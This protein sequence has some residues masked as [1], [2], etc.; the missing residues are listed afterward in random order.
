[1]GRAETEGMAMGVEIMEDTA[2]VGGEAMIEMT[3]VAETERE[4]LGGRAGKRIQV[5][6]LLRRE[7][8]GEAEKRRATKTVQTRGFISPGCLQ[9]SRKM[10]CSSTLVCSARWLG[11]SR[12]EGTQTS[13]RTRSVFMRRTTSVKVTPV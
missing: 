12:S 4:V 6:A 7:W 5:Q 3:A 11:R 1:M 13:G 9:I 2:I 10:T 8:S